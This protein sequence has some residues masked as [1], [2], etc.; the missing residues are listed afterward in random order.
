MEVFADCFSLPFKEQLYPRV[1]NM[2]E[3]LGRANDSHV[4]TGRLTEL[5]H[6]L[7][8]AWPGEWERLRLGVEGLLR[9]HRSR[10]P[11]EKRR[12]LAWWQLWQAEGKAFF[13]NLIGQDWLVDG[14]DAGTSG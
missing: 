4:A 3:I 6:A 11:R 14:S 10:L 2:Q 13:D 5:R 1:E 7:K 8:T 12:F 9:S